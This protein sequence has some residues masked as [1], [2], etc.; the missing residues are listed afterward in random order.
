MT[1]TV[2]L[3]ILCAGKGWQMNSSNLT[4]EPTLWWVAGADARILAGCPRADQIFVQHLG[5]SLIG[6]FIFVF[7]ITVVSILVAFPELKDSVA[8]LSLAPLFAFLIAMMV[9]LVDRLFIQYDWD[10]QAA[11]QRRE[12]ARAK[13][14]RAPI[15]ERTTAKIFESD[16]NHFFRRVKRFI[17]IWSRVLLSA[18]IGLTIASFLELVIYKNEIKTTIHRLHYEENKSI[19]DE[20][21][22]RTVLLDQEIEKA[23]GER[24]RFIQLKASAESELNKLTL[25]VPPLPSDESV[26]QMDTQIADLR[27]KIASE[28]SKVQQY[29][30]DMIAELRG[31]Q[32]NPW[33]SLVPGIGPRYQTAQDLKSL[34]EAAI[35]Q[36]RS[37]IDALETEKR[38]VTSN[39]EAEIQTAKRNA[40]GH[41]KELRTYIDGLSISLQKAQSHLSKLELTRDSK[42]QQFVAAQKN[43]PGFLTISFGV[44][45]QFRALRTIYARYGSTFEMYMI[46]FLIM[47]LEM[48]PVLQ[49]VLL[50]PATLYAVRLGA[51]KRAGAY[52]H[53]DEEVKLKQEHLRRKWEATYDEESD[54]MGLERVR[55]ANVTSLHEGKG[56]V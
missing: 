23:R 40:E 27:R 18:A 33:N 34:S 37:D 15:E 14:E 5:I 22:S 36:Y 20:I 17:V 9:F 11:E 41:E 51:I 48:T 21:N 50:S 3:G 43:K 28:Q 19:Y 49:K 45:S 52:E 44:A 8:S 29:N 26:R 56:A 12:L 55:Q 13:W 4:K 46:K 7:L 1:S 32:I 24:N 38:K 30:E 47:L 39:R 53:F 6:A 31:T 16:W 25:S 54:G 35:T 2:E 10:Y 42:I